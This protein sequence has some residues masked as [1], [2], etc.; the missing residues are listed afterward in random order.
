MYRDHPIGKG[1]SR[2]RLPMLADDARF[3]AVVTAIPVVA[4]GS[5]ALP[6]VAPIVLTMAVYG[7]GALAVL[8]FASRAGVMHRFGPANRITL[9]RVGL[10]AVVAG[11]LAAADR[12]ETVNW[13]VICTLAGIALALDGID[14]WVARRHALSSRFGARFDMETDAALILVLSLLIGLSGKAGLW[15]IAVGAMRYLFVVAGWLSSTLARPLPPS[16]PRRTVCAIQVAALLV[17]LLPVVTPAMA[18]AIGG[19]ALVILCLSFLRDILWLV[20]QPANRSP[21]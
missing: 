14:G 4:L 12:P 21:A 1:D 2:F 19:T 18:A 15:I 3:L 8:Y 16:T 5:A 20:R 7:T 17:C 9:L 11:A 6:A 13:W 10:T